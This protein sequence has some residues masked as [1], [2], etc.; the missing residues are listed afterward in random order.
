L[1]GPAVGAAAVFVRKGLPS[2][3]ANDINSCGEPAFKPF[4]AAARRAGPASDATELAGQVLCREVAMSSRARTRRRE[5]LACRGG[6]LRCS[7]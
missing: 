1:L 2:L 7:L 5:S 6:R 4:A 3:A